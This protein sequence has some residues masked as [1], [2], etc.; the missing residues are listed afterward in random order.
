MKIENVS[1][2]NLSQYRIEYMGLAMVLVVFYHAPFSVRDSIVATIKYFGFA[3]VDIFVFLFGWGGYCSYIKDHDGYAY[4]CRRIKKLFPTYF[5]FCLLWLPFQCVT[6]SMC[7]KSVIGNLF[8]MEGFTGSGNE[9]NWYITCLVVFC[10]I[11]PYLSEFISRN[12]RKGNLLIIVV[13]FLVSVAFWNNHSIMIASRIPL[14]IL[15]MIFGKNKDA[16]IRKKIWVCSVIALICGVI[17]LESSFL[18][19]HESYLEMGIYWYPQILIIPAGFMIFFSFFQHF[20]RMVMIGTLRSILRVIGENTFEIY[21]SHIFLNRIAL[22][23]DIQ[24]SVILFFIC[25]GGILPI[26]FIIKILSRNVSSLWMKRK[27]AL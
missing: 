3:G 8:A 23:L 1:F 5:A 25:I 9:Y 16:V 21:L 14:L 10:I 22:K 17:S 11:V 2:D 24:N 19:W 13:S 7:Y 4:L 26:V 6:S 18:L 20:D 15:G 27:G 12:D